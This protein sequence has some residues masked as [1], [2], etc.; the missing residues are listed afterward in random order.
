MKTATDQTLTKGVADLSLKIRFTALERNNLVVSTEAG[1]WVPAGYDPDDTPPLGSGE[2][3]AVAGVS[4][5]LSLYP[6]PAYLSSSFGIRLR[7]GIITNEFYG[8]AE[9]GAF[10]HPKLLIRGRLDLVES[11]SDNTTTFD[12]MEQVTEQGYI[13]VGPGVSVIASSSWQLHVDARWTVKG[14]TTSKI[15]SVGAGIAYTW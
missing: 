12:V 1:L 5:G 4:A 15:K 6:I 13:T 11:T 8:H 14:R 10:A 3:D 9:G 2:F 7:G